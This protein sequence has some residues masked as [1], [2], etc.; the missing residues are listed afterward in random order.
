ML[1]VGCGNVLIA[2][3]VLC[4]YQISFVFLLGLC[5][6]R[7]A[8]AC[9]SSLYVLF[10]VLCTLILSLSLPLPLSVFFLLVRRELS[11]YHVDPPSFSHKGGAEKPLT[12]MIVTRSEKD[13]PQIKSPSPTN[14]AL[15]EMVAGCPH[16]PTALD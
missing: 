2:G 14:H 7:K 3:V 1:R 11:T 8:V 9:Y 6:A 15:V 10:C 13:S 4:V 12:C 5:V 16:P